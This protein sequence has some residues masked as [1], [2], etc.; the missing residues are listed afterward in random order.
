MNESE[1]KTNYSLGTK[2]GLGILGGIT[3]ASL[4]AGCAGFKNTLIKTLHPF[5][6]TT[7]ARISE[8]AFTNTS[9]EDFA[10]SKDITQ[11]YD[12]Y[13]WENKEGALGAIVL[14]NKTDSY[15]GVNEKK[16]YPRIIPI[17]EGWES[18]KNSD[19]EKISK[20]FENG[21]RVLAY[22]PC[23]NSEGI[24]RIPIAYSFKANDGTSLNFRYIGTEKGEIE[25]YSVRALKKRY[26]IPGKGGGNAGLGSTSST[27]DQSGR[28]G[29]SGSQSR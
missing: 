25:N 28:G 10:N 6:S 13:A 22:L 7:T 16:H 1:R 24:R 4:L 27:G 14:D 21:K 5:N 26:E 15:K 9:L 18:L 23:N 8:K 11:K 2:I 3:G 20:E 29:N 19:L 17:G 12:V